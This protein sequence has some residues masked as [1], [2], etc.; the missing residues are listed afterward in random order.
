VAHPPRFREV[1]DALLYL[2]AKETLTRSVPEAGHWSPDELSELDRR[3]Q[4]L[5]GQ[6]LDRGVLFK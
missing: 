4:V 3:N 6:P 2:G 1:A 5:F